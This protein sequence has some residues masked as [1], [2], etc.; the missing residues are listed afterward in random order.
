MP[1]IPFWFCFISLLLIVAKQQ[2]SLKAKIGGAKDE[3]QDDDEEDKEKKSIA[4]GRGKNIYYDND[5]VNN[6]WLYFP[7]TII[8]N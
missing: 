5:K 6:I 7:K 1:Q 2:K 3:T 8:L 4:W